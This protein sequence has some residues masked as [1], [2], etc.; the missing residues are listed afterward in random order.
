MLSN[1]EFLHILEGSQYNFLRENEH[2]G[3]NIMFL[4]LGG[5][6]AIGTSRPESDVDVRG[7]AGMRRSD[8][9]GFSKF[10][11]IRDNKLDVTVLSFNHT[12]NLL[13]SASPHAMEMFGA[14][15][16]HYAWVSKTGRILL[17]N[18][19]VFYSQQAYDSFCAYAHQQMMLL[20]NSVARDR[21][22]VD[23]REKYILEK[24][25]RQIE[26]INGRYQSI[27]EGG[28]RLYLSE[29]QG[30]GRGKEELYMDVALT[31]YPVR[32][33]KNLIGERNEIT[34]TYGKINHRNK[35]KDNLHLNKHMAHLVRL[36]LMA[37]D[38]LETGKLMLYREKDKD[39]LLDII[40]G[41]YMD[42]AGF[43]RPEFY[44][45][46]QDLRSQVDY[47]KKNSILP[48]EPDRTKAEELICEINYMSLTGQN[49]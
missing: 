33:Y 29:S 40:N 2:L 22:G 28:M 25:E 32:D 41:K 27:P 20:K 18:V 31:K 4:V 43:V 21:L 9:L 38:F 37:K 17:D 15:P 48:V 12:E 3:R 13:L 36:Y 11:A 30:E 39:F 10:E 23:E 7:V 42:E 34:K 47:A 35:K 1:E 16:E 6:H 49:S 5:S 8:L 24:C 45:M 19:D 46:V 26:N 14:R 44:T